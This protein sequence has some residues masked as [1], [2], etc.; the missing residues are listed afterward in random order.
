MGMRGYRGS[1]AE[2]EDRKLG[3]RVGGTCR[4]LAEGAPLAKID[5]IEIDNDGDPWFHLSFPETEDKP[6]RVERSEII[7]LVHGGTS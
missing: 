7:P 4:W 3:I 6:I 1:P 5:R 2:A